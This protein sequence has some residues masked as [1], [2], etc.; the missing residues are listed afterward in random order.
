MYSQEQ[1]EKYPFFREKLEETDLSGML[2][3]LTGLVSRGNI[4][5]FAQ[6]LIDHDVPFSFAMLD[7]DNFKFIN[8][9]YRLRG[10]ACVR[11]CLKNNVPILH[12]GII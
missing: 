7:L 10:K 9:N 5:W 11:N 8:D 2:D 6:W 12:L 3:Q 4:L 1:L